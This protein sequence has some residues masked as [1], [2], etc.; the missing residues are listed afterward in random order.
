MDESMMEPTVVL[1]AEEIGFYRNNGFLVLRSITTEEEVARMRQ[2]YDRIFSSRAGREVGD[3]Y[4]LAGSDEEGAQAVLPQIMNPS[5]Y[6]PELKVGLFRANGL[7][8]A[9]QLLGE[10]VQTISEH[11]IFKPAQYGAETPWHQDEAYRD[12]N[13]QY[14][15]F[16]LWIP[17]QEATI[18]NGCMWFVPGS[19]LQDVRPH[20]SI[21]YDMRV[22]G[23][24]IDDPPTMDKAVPCPIPAGGCTIH[25]NRTLHYAGANRSDTPRRALIINYAVEPKPWNGAPRDFYWNR[26]KQ[27]PRAAR[28]RA[29]A[30][31]ARPE[32]H[33]G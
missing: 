32:K 33:S 4:D 3:Q 7:A 10:Q 1:T 29:A 31:N 5:K 12:P 15:S 27:P 23:L 14:T 13:L 19:H 30:A 21:G 17:L 9:R 11:A 28:A 24:E 6:A 2:A 25:A 8:I 18:E 16:A 20:H 22:H 26:L